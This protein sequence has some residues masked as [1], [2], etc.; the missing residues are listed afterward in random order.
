MTS[1]R[2]LISEPKVIQKYPVLS[3]RQIEE[4]RKGIA[5]ADLG[6][7]ASDEDVK[8]TINKWTRPFR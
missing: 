1:R 5:E 7:F 3:Q 2:R 4:V 8:R 6:D